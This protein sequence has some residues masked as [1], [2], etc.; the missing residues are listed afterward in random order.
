[1]RQ[2]KKALPPGTM[3]D[4]CGIP[5]TFGVVLGEGGYGRVY[6]GT[7]EGSDRSEDVAL[8]VALDRE[9][10]EELFAEHQ[11]LQKKGISEIRGAALQQGVD[12]FIDPT[13]M[14]DTAVAVYPLV[15]G[16]NMQQG[17]KR[18]VPADGASFLLAQMARTAHD[19]HKQGVAHCDI[20][21]ENAIMEEDGKVSVIDW[22]SMKEIGS[23]HPQIAGTPQYLA[24]EIAYAT[25]REIPVTG[26]EDVYAIGMA[27]A[28]LMNG[29]HHRGYIADFKARGDMIGM[30]QAIQ[31]DR[32][33]PEVP[34]ERMTFILQRACHPNPNKRSTALDLMTDLSVYPEARQCFSPEEKT[35]IMDNLSKRNGWMNRLVRGER[36]YQLDADI[37][38]SFLDELPENHPSRKNLQD[39]AKLSPLGLQSR[40]LN[41]GQIAR[42]MEPTMKVDPKEFG[43]D[44]DLAKRDTSSIPIFEGPRR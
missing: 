36:S 24:P 2:D 3:V 19:A 18:P 1:M 37:A 34:D 5:C 6:R 10:S 29:K 21:L 13:D 32:T 17:V 4:V 12:R 20:K 7:L 22:G 30:V 42:S 39:V 28:L 25:S 27:G 16:R 38:R 14:K 23:K 35:E 15:R 9:G 11:L 31:K 33:V 44:P 41:E 26:K 40:P 8:K 43:A